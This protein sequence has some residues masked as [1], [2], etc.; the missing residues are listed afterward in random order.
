MSL[1]TTRFAHTSTAQIPVLIPIYGSRHDSFR[2]PFDGTYKCGSS[3]ASEFRLEFPGA[4][5]AHCCFIREAGTF[6]IKRLKGQVWINDLPVHGLTRLTEGD[7]IS[8][9]PILFRLEHLEASSTS[10]EP[11][12]RQLPVQDTSVQTALQEE[13][14]EHQRLMA[15]RQQQELAAIENARSELS[16]QEA[17]LRALREQTEAAEAELCIQKSE[18]QQQRDDMDHQRQM[19]AEQQQELAA[20][21]NARSELSQQEAE[22][23]ALREQTEAAEAELCIQKSELQQQRDDIDHQRQML[24]EQQQELAAIENARS[25]LSQQEAELRALREQ[26][27]AAEAELCIQK[28]ELQQQRDDMDHQRQMLAEQQ[29]ELAAIEN[30]RSELSQQEAELRALR[31]QTEAAEAELCIQKSELQQQRDDMDQQRQ[32]LAEQQQELAAIENARSE[33]SQQEAELR[34]LREQTEAAEAELRIQKS[35]LQMQRDDIDHQRQMLAEQQQELAAVENARSELSQQEAEL[36]ALREQTEAA[37]AE[38]CIQKSE[39]QMQRDDIDH[40]RQMLAEQQQELAAIE[41]ARSE[42][43][44]QE[45]ELRALREQT[46]AAEAELCIQKSE[47]QQQRDDMDQQRQMLAEQQQELAAIENARSELSQQET[48]LSYQ[49]ESLALADQQRIEDR[50][51]EL[52][53]WQSEIE[54]RAKELS[55]RLVELKSYRSEQRAAMAAAES[56]RTALQSA[57]EDLRCDRN[58]LS[59]LRQELASDESRIAEREAMVAHQLEDLRSRFAVLDLR[60]AEQKHHGSEIDSRSA[61]VHRQI[62]QFKKDRQIHRETVAGASLDTLSRELDHRAELLDRRDDELC[63]RA[64]RM[65]QSENDLDSRRHQLLEARQQLEQARAEIQVAI[66]QRPES[67]LHATA[68]VQNGDHDSSGWRELQTD[69]NITPDADRSGDHYL[70]ES[71]SLGQSPATGLRS[72]LAGLFGLPKPTAED[73]APPPVPLFDDTDVSLPTGENKTV[74][75]HFGPGVPPLVEAQTTSE[76]D[77]GAEFTR[78]ENSD[79]FVRDYMEQLLSRGRKTAG[80]VLPGELKPAEQRSRH[81]T[82][83]AAETVHEPVRKSGPKVKSFIEQYMAGTMGNLVSDEPLTPSESMN[84]E[85]DVIAQAVPSRQK[86]DLQKLRDNMDSFRKLST[87]SVDNA[88]A[89]HAIK[90]ERD[91]FMSRFAFAAILV[92]MTLVVGIANAKGVTDSPM[93]TWVTLTAAIALLSE[94]YRRY[95]AIKVHSRNPLELLFSSD[96][97]SGPPQLSIDM[98]TKADP[99]PGTPAVTDLDN[100]NTIREECFEA[101]TPASHERHS[102]MDSPASWTEKY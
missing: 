89:S 11:A 13:M 55:A 39:L 51:L 5:A 57:A 45:A 60:A 62:Q 82:A 26:T 98:I 102:L 100:D 43:S 86:M 54:S 70:V 4:E 91:G 63:E 22:L 78:E 48:E 32:M 53:D 49:A 97:P 96:E 35:E 42:L 74:A 73:Y 59:Q 12:V 38:L 30:A 52:L 65:E 44:Q 6:S 64:R 56:E 47:L 31:E 71:N 85:N 14:L 33:L 80:T 101:S 17:E 69:S 7:L 10:P 8:L 94:V 18:L 9:G 25:E 28:S 77:T 92:T 81:A 95:I 34:A 46:E 16:Q 23:R 83:A 20:I 90:M 41:N 50:Q 19:L 58:A 99:V 29:Q 1:A 61:E 67:A 27:E 87:L 24:A 21:E 37:E 79:D 75:F 68:F 76:V 15:M 72:E 3:A 36:R 88:L 84:E 66:C 2:A 40:Q 93:L